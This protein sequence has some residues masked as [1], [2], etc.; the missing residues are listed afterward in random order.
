MPSD[1][2]KKEEETLLLTASLASTVHEVGPL[3]SLSPVCVS[4]SY[5]TRLFR[6]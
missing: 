2:K 5:Y 6:P 4:P 3:D 1:T